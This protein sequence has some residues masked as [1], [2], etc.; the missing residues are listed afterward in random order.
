MRHRWLRR[1]QIPLVLALL[2]WALQHRPALQPFLDQIR[3]AAL[4]ALLGDRFAPSDE[5][6]IGIAV[7]SVKRLAALGA[8]LDNF[9]FRAVRTFHPDGLLLDVLAGRVIAA[10]G[11]LAEP[12]G[13]ENHLIVALRAG[14]IERHIGLLLCPADGLGGLAIRI[15]GACEKLAKAALL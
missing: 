3:T 7:A 1:G 2:I 8:A 4:R 10:R 11:E 5:R 15:S 14:F 12:A 6:A 13:L 9:A